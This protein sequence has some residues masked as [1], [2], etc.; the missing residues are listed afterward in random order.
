MIKWLEFV[1]V[2]KIFEEIRGDNFN[3]RSIRFSLIPPT[4]YCQNLSIEIILKLRNNEYKQLIYLMDYDDLSLLIRKDKSRKCLSKNDILRVV[5]KLSR[6]S[7]MWI[8]SRNYY[9][10]KKV[11]YFREF[12]V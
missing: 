1:E 10:R 5:H 6:E 2:K 11:V 12:A 9:K 4:S 3:I 7:S 8:A